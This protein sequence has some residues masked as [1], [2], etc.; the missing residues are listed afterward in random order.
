MRATTIKLDGDLYEKVGRL[1]PADQSATAYVRA[2]I[3]REH[4]RCQQQL[5]AEA[6]QAFLLAHP[7]EQAELETWAQAPLA[8]TPAAPKTALPS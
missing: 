1:K 4:S 2:L 8:D 7:E 3:E 5:A 6:Y